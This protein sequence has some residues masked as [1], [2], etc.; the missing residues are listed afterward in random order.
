[1]YARRY[2]LEGTTAADGSLTLY[3]DGPVNGRV[4]D[5]QYVKTDFVDGSTM[6]LTAET[7]GKAIWSETGV[8]AS[9]GRAPRQA[10]HGV[11]GAAALYAA[12]GTAVRDVI[13]LAD[14]RLKLVIS[15]GG[16]AKKG[17][18]YVTVG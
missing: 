4:L 10:T 3:S 15:A 13:T 12:A 16:N 14:E 18:W 9:A 2:K 8:N 11:D 17:T 6:T 7:S 1:M 5:V